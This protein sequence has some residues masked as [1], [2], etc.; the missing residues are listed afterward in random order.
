[1]FYVAPLLCIAL[2]AWVEHRRA[3]AP[4]ARD[5]R[6]S[7]VRASRRR[8]PVRPL[9]HD[10][11]DHGHA[12]AA[13]ALVAA[14]SIS[15]RAGF[16]SSLSDSPLVLA[17]AFLFVPG[18]YALVLP[19]LV[20]GLW[21]VAVKPIWF[22]KHGFERFSRG[23]LFQGIRTVD[24]D[25]IDQKLPE[26]RPRRLPL[27][28]PHRPA[29]REPERVLQPGGRAGLLRHRSDARRPPRDP[30]PDRPED[31]SGHAPRREPRAGSVPAGGLVVRSRRHSD[32]ARTRAGASRCGACDHRSCPRRSSTGSIR[33]TRGPARRSR[34]RD[35]G[36]RR[37]GSPSRSRATRTSS[38]SRSRSSRARTVGSSGAYG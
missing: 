30:R 24:R 16:L 6:C 29:H 4:V 1:M 17:A 14:G 28:G 5:D 21:I 35:D 19:L 7:R 18:R 9:P 31:R 10:L 25:W 2:L 22:G 20:L 32:R 11:G 27:D 34:T 13:A 37:D 12:H 3:A 23:A 38:S 15:A 8:D 33:T 26:R 36:A